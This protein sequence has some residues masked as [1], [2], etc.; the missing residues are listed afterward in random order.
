MHHVQWAGDNQ[1]QRRTFA[2]P[3]QAGWAAVATA[4]EKRQG[5]RAA[6]GKAARARAAGAREAEGE[7]AEEAASAG[8]A[9]AE[10]VEVGVMGRG[11][12]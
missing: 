12:A 8:A 7:G 5:A 3:G 9:Q 10:A 1:A 11:A 2:S 6:V 4:G